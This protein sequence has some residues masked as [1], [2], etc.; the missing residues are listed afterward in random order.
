VHHFE[1]SRDGI[2]QEVCLADDF[3]RD[4]CR[5]RQN[6]PQPI[7]NDRW[8]LVVF[9]LFLQ[10]LDRQE[11]PSAPDQPIPGT[12]LKCHPSNTEDSLCNW[13]QLNDVNILLVVIS[14]S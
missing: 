8:N 13:V 5:K 1:H 7:E 10:E 9:I 6:A 3:V 11:L 4:L 12:N 14:E 2:L